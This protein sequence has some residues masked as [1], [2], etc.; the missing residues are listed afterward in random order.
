MSG[1]KDG[2]SNGGLLGGVATSMLG[3]YKPDDDKNKRSEVGGTGISGVAAPV[4]ESRHQKESRLASKRN[5]VLGE[6]AMIQRKLLEVD[7][8]RKRLNDDFN[9]RRRGEH[10]DKVQA[11]H[12]V[13]YAA[14]QAERQDPV[15]RGQKRK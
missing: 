14:R 11:E 9:R 12:K 10:E 6:K 15:A 3:N 2:P 1:P 5:A 8:M 7:L 13:L 4:I